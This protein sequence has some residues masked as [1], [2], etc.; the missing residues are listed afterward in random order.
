MLNL[1]SPVKPVVAF[2]ANGGAAR[3]GAAGRRAVD[4]VLYEVVLDIRGVEG[5]DPLAFY[6]HRGLL[7]NRQL[8]T[9]PELR[10]KDFLV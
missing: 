7:W 3:A 6:R 9:V 5:F 10:P 8:P 2:D 1:P 4:A